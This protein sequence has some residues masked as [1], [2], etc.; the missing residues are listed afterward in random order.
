MN[1]RAAV[2]AGIVAGI[3]ATIVQLALWWIASLPVLHMLL[4]DARLAAAIVMGSSVLPPPVSFE[5]NVLLVATLVHFALSAA[6]GL[7]Q[8]PLVSRVPLRLAVITGAVFGLSLYAVNMYGFT[9]LFPWFEAS[10]DWITAITHAA[11]G[12]TAAATYR[13]WNRFDEL[14]RTTRRRP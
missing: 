10:R 4:R 5:W 1:W 8:A 3:I 2:G 6:Y 12:A 11:F 9:L 14:W 13:Y 7:L